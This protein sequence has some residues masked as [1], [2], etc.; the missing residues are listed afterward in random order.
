[1]APVESEREQLAKQHVAMAAAR[2]PGPDYY[3]HL[4]RLHELLKPK[5]YVEIGIRLGNSMRLAGRDTLCIG[6]DPEPA[7]TGEMPPRL[8]AF[9]QTSDDFFARPDVSKIFGDA[10]FDLAFIDG[11]HLWEQALKDFINLE[12]FAGPDS[13]ILLHD[14]IPLDEVTAARERTTDF[15]SGDVW[16]L[17]ACLHV[18]RPDLRMAMIPTRHTGLCLVANLDPN[19][20]LL[21]ERFEE[22]F[23]KWT[24]RTL[25]D[26]AAHPDWMP[27]TIANDFDAVASWIAANV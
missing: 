11:L 14:C 16:K 25:A 18:E 9:A 7:L 8:Q 21:S 24:P 4:A 15:Y 6:I 27:P 23:D 12:R 5:S 1:M 20:R 10:P 13:L 2:L 17:S 22:L 19:S 3:K 26:L